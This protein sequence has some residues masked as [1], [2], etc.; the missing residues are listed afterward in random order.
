[1]RIINLLILTSSILNTN[2]LH[3]QNPNLNYKYAI[4]LGN[5]S[6]YK[7]NFTTFG[8]SSARNDK[9]LQILQPLITLQRKT[10]NNNFV[11]IELSSLNINSNRSSFY[12]YN[13]S[14]PYNTS[15]EPLYKQR[16]TNIAV[17]AEYIFVYGKIKDKRLV[18]NVG[19]G[20]M[21]SYNKMNYIS[22]SPMLYS[23]SITTL[24]CSVYIS[25]KLTYFLKS[26]YFIDLSLPLNLAEFSLN[27]SYNSNPKLDLN[28]RKTSTFN[29]DGLTTSFGF[30]L[31][32]GIKL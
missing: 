32:F 22:A 9:T 15:K 4:K 29:F 14:P 21:T 23:N 12:V 24:G 18:S 17:R 16:N 3:A 5:S 25:P 6:S 10:Q 8:R 26:K 1:M 11:E 27:S 7:S 2:I 30:R 13:D 31:G 19:V 28:N 20:L